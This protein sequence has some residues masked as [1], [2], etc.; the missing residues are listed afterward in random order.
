MSLTKAIYQGMIGS[1]LETG[2]SIDKL[3][4]DKQILCITLPQHSYF[5]EMSSAIKC[6]EDYARRIKETWIEM[7]IFSEGCKVLYK[8]KDINWTKEMGKENFNNNIDKVL[9]G[10]I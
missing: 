5:Y 10:V 3:D 2:V 7:G 9:R 4:T 1:M 8:T 6:A